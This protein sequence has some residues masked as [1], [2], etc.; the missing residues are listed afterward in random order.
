MSLEE[1]L[2]EFIKMLDNDEL[3]P[4]HYME[5][6]RALVEAQALVATPQ[7]RQKRVYGFKDAID[8]M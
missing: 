2:G 8:L 6:K 1:R 7:K 4:R 3:G 5:L